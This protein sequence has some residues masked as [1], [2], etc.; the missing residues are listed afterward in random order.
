[1]IHG[2]GDKSEELRRESS[3]ERAGVRLYEHPPYLPLTHASP[4]CSL[5]RK[6]LIRIE[7]ITFAPKPKTY[8]TLYE[9]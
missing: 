4:T 3:V 1:M 9:L 5:Q 6:G 8:A 2:E 7:S